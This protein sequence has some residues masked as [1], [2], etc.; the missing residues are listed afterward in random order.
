MDLPI[1]AE[2]KCSGKLCGHISDLILNPVTDTVTHIVVRSV[3]AHHQ[4]YVLPVRDIVD[5]SVNCIHLPF[6]A[7]Q[8]ENMQHFI[9]TDFL[10][11]ELPTYLTGSYRVLPFVV[12]ETKVV[13]K[14]HEHI[15]PGELAIHRG[16]QVNA[17]DQRVGQVNEFLVDPGTGKITHLILREGHL[18]G[19]K[20]VVIPLGLIDRIDGDAV[21]LKATKSA[22]DKL[23]DIPVHRKWEC[24]D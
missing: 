10:K 16:A 11:V 5:A 21:Y 24:E 15:P 12:P 20:D 23:P 1:G 9:E 19:K 17:L 22:L 14:E 3:E 6:S 7:E 4:E 13:T 8:F 2:V 18:W